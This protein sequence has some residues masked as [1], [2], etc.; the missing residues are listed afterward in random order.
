V[1]YEKSV[2][3]QCM[4]LKIDAKIRIE[5]L[6]YTLPRTE[7]MNEDRVKAVNLS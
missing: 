4:K 1:K 7:D 3:C 2:F 6:I 5:R